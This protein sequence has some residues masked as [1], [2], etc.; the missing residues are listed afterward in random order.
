VNLATGRVV[1]SVAIPAGPFGEGIVDSGDQLIS[2]TWQGG[3]GYRWNLH[4]LTRLGEWNY[5]G[6]GWA[7]TRNATDLI[8]SDGTAQLRFLHP[9]TL[10]ERRRLDVTLRGQ[11]LERINELEWIDG[12]I[13]A[14]VWLTAFIVRIDPATGRVTGLI[15]LRSLAAENAGADPDKVLNGIAWDPAGHRLFVTGKNW[16]HLY[17]IQLVPHAGPV[18]T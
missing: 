3:V 8:M 12:E 2:L 16:S 11:P 4:S 15:D 5:P 9:V 14:N 13:Y 18:P 6:E 17:E 1:Q 10:A 7:L